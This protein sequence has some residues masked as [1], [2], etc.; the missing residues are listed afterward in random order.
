MNKTELKYFEK[1]QK[2]RKEDLKVFSKP[3]NRGFLSSVIDKYTESAHFIYELL[4]NADDALATKA[5]FRL[6]K[7]GLTFVHNGTVR[8]TIS[9]PDNIIEDRK[10]G[11]LGHLN[12]ITYTGFSTKDKE[13]TINKIGKFGVGFKAVFQYTNTPHIYDDSICFKIEDFF[14]P[15]IIEDQAGRR[16]GETVFYLPFNKEGQNQEKA[17]FEIANRLCHL[18]NPLLFLHNLKVVKWKDEEHQGKYSQKVSEERSIR[19]IDCKFLILENSYENTRRRLW[20]FSKETDVEGRKFPI[21]VGFYTINGKIDTQNRSNIYCYFPTKQ[22]INVCFVMHAPFVLTDSRE[23]I[24]ELDANDLLFEQLADLAAKSLVCLRDIGL[25]EGHKPLLDDSLAEII[26]VRE[27][28]ET[29]IMRHF[30][31]AFNTVLQTEKLFPSR[32]RGIYLAANEACICPQATLRELLCKEQ[33]MFLTGKKVDFVFEDVRFDEVDIRYYKGIGVEEFTSDKF[34]E[35]IGYVFLQAQKISWIKQFYKYLYD[36]AKPLWKKDTRLYAP[37]PV[38]KNKTIILL[39]DGSFSQLRADIYLNNNGLPDTKAVNQEIIQDDDVR[40]FFK[41]FGVKESPEVI[42]YLRNAILPRYQHD[43]VSIDNVEELSSDLKLIAAIYKLDSSNKDDILKLIKENWKA[44]GVNCHGERKLCEIGKLYADEALLRKYFGNNSK[45]LF[46]DKSYYQ[47]SEEDEEVCANLFSELHFQSVPKVYQNLVAE[48]HESYLYS[49]SRCWDSNLASPF[50]EIFNNA[51]SSL[52]SYLYQ[53]KYEYYQ[54]VDAMF[55]DFTMHGLFGALKSIDSIEDSICVWNYIIDVA[56]NQKQQNPLEILSVIEYRPK[57]ARYSSTFPALSRPSSILNLIR[58]AAWIYDNTGKKCTPQELYVEDIDNRYDN[59]DKLSEILRIAHSPRFMDDVHLEQCSEET[60][61]EVNLG[62]LLI[63]EGFDRYTPEERAE[64]QK[65]WEN[66][67]R[68]EGVA[69]QKRRR[70]VNNQSS[71]IF[72]QDHQKDYTA[73]ELFDGIPE[74]IKPRNIIRKT[75]EENLE[76]I[77][78][79]QNE[80]LLEAARKQELQEIASNCEKY[81]FLWYKTLLELEYLNS[82]EA[83]YGKKGIKISFGKIEADKDSSKML[84]LRQPSRYIPQELEECSDITVTFYFK[85]SASKFPLTFEVANVKDYTLRLKCKNESTDKVQFLL[86]NA[87]WLVR[88]DIETGTL[89]QLIDTLRSAYNA[90]PYEDAYS[91]RDNIKRDLHFVFGP[92]GTGKTTYLAK[93]LKCLMSCEFLNPTTRKTKILVLCPTNKACDVLLQKVIDSYGDNGMD[94]FCRF[95]AT[96]EESLEP[97]LCDSTLPVLMLDKIC[98]ISTMARFHYDGFDEADLSEMDWDYI[99]IDEASMIPIA[100]VT[101]VIDRCPHAKIVIAGDPFQI[102]P[103]VHEDLWKNENIYTMVELNSFTAPKTVPCNFKIT[104]LSIQYRSVPA[105]GELFS[106]Y[107][108]NGALSHN[109]GSASQRPLKL[110][111]F[112]SRAI[113]FVTFP[114]KSYDSLYQSHHLSTSNVHLY[115]VLLVFEFMS[116]LTKQI[117]ENHKGVFYRIGVICPYR[118]QAEMINKIWEQRTL[119]TENVEVCIGTVHGFQGDECD[120]ILAVYN[121]PASGMKMFA[122]KTFMNRKNILNVAISRAKDYLFL[123]MPDKEYESFDNLTEIRMMGKIVV[124]NN[125]ERSVCSSEKLE[126]V[127]FGNSNFIEDNTFVTSHQLTN[128]YTEPS[129]K[130]EIRIDDNSVDV[131]IMPD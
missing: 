53:K 17:Y 105:I 23:G 28:K 77:E 80:A 131:Q 26:I 90:L 119:K 20:M 11:K 4:Q 100:Y 57:Y 64:M 30:Y 93:E 116:Y 16:K 42:V 95:K 126:G 66:K 127:L 101:Y 43:M 49:T 14:V 79:V 34:G 13:G 60:K 31:R 86:N 37:T 110:D 24:R 94:F 89:I 124:D 83:S 35:K 47:I 51:A 68:I 63:A 38:L 96:G 46:L 48:Y 3:E 15:Y 10:N 2:S 97:Y 84:I 102:E 27:P 21:C 82:G 76:S 69:E 65:L 55:Y 111:G 58:E 104:N 56:F 71:D 32:K 78:Q 128:V 120:V 45:V 91:F 88:A 115:S 18:D 107:A 52:K 62:R 106:Q 103:I 19:G 87:D 113:N 7:D 121:P 5:E 61:H 12:A 70:S 41:A 81:S 22:K 125:L 75:P 25:S 109:R 98:V 39:D 74:P 85:N 29:D 72:P 40:A 122:D 130:Y 33:L 54:V 59:I 114:V 117:S 67:K 1:L 8:F 44:V 108:Y 118:A 36:H 6:S 50:K 73:E 99:V 9:N 129:T 123:L 92:P 112:E